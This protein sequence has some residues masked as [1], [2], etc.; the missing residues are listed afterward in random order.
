MEQW[1]SEILEGWFLKGCYPFLIFFNTNF[2]INPK[3][4]LSR[5]PLLQ[6]F[7]IPIGAKPL[8]INIYNEVWQVD[9]IF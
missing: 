9:K 6:H 3:I 1:N 2:A 8:T 4:A 7:I 5:H